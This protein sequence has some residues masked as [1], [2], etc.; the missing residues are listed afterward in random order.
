MNMAFNYSELQQKLDKYF[1]NT[2]VA[3]DK[4]I[5][6][7]AD[8]AKDVTVE[9]YDL[10]GS[11]KT[12]SFPNRAK[13][14]NDFIANVNS[15]M[16]KVFYVDQENGDD[17]NDGSQN[18]PF[19]TLNKAIDSV[20]NGGVGDIVLLSNVDLTNSI[21]VIDKT[22]VIRSYNAGKYGC[23]VS[24]ENYPWI[25]QRKQLSDNTKVYPAGFRVRNGLVYFYYVNIATLTVDDDDLGKSIYWPGFIS[26]FDGSKEVILTFA[27]IIN[28][29]DTEFIERQ[30]GPGGMID[31]GLYATKIKLVHPH[32]KNYAPKFINIEES[33]KT[34]SLSTQGTS[35]VDS[36]DNAIQWANVINGIVRDS[37]GIPRNII[38]NIIL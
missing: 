10:D 11:L 26:R 34:I 12:V 15:A 29:N 38:S 14:V 27:S 7:V 36:N 8:P 21:S 18:A 31:I 37:N 9:Y 13:L 20:P 28:V 25:T 16:N 5:E 6:F 32:A 2:A 22:I 19:K 17:G 1:Y 23:C 35:V 4:W 33:S 3:I 30:T 24:N